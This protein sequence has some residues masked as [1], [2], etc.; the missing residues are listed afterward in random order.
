MNW[1]MRDNPHGLEE[2]KSIVLVGNP[3]TGKSV[4]FGELTRQFAE[5]SN[6]PGTTLLLSEGWMA[7]FV[8]IDTPGVYGLYSSKEE[9]VVRQAVEAS[10]IV[11]NVMDATNLERGLWLALELLETGKT[12]FNVLNMWDEVETTGLVIDVERLGSLLGTP[13][14]TT[15][16]VKGVGIKELVGAITSHMEAPAERSL[17]QTA[18]FSLDDA[19]G[20]SELSSSGTAEATLSRRQRIEDILEGVLVRVPERRGLADVLSEIMIRPLTGVPLALAILGGVFYLIGAFVAQD[21]VAFTEGVIFQQIYEPAVR[22]I[23][24][25]VLS[26]PLYEI[27]AGEFGVLTMTVTYVLGLLLPL[28]F[29]FYVLMALLED[30]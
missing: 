19:L 10:G 12:V 7:D 18:D 22:L 23:V 20:T 14:F 21:L 29:A 3:N 28:V 13:V 24:G 2:I 8:V 26:G 16:A 4:L 6:Y 30:T 25:S 9:E 17:S 27:I 1:R 5:V 15:V 11:I